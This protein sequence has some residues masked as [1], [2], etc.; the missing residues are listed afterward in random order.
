MRR[1]IAPFAA[2]PVSFVL[3]SSALA[4]SS[5]SV[6]D[7]N[8]V[9]WACFDNSGSVRFVADANA[10]CPKNWYGPVS[11]NQVGPQ[12]PEGVAGADGQSAYELAVAGGYSGSLSE[13]LAS[14]VGPQGP[15]GE[16]GVQGPKGD[17]GDTGATGATGATGPQG[18]QGEQ[19]LTGATGATGPQGPQGETGATGPAGPAGPTGP[20]GPQGP[21]GDTGATGATGPTGPQGPAGATGATGPAGPAGPVGGDVTET[22]TWTPVFT[23]NS[24]AAT[25]TTATLIEAGSTLTGVSGSITVTGCANGLAMVGWSKNYAGG[26]VAQVLNIS[27][28]DTPVTL[29]LTPSSTTPS[30]DVHLFFT[31]QCGL[32]GTYTT[33]PAS[34]T[35]T[36]TMTWQ[37]PARAIN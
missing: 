19:G 30:S 25:A 26:D 1:R 9:Y 24:L 36:V 10:G 12:G 5:L 34:V 27:A 37:H 17:S 14:L 11:W 29:S 16:Q 20:Q 7:S 13:W 2:L 18:P 32:G 15:Q 22:V 3:V 4:G 23:A 31:V 28:G 35:G 6:P 8:G 33:P 21:K